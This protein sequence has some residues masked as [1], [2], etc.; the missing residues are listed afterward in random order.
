MHKCLCV[1]SAV[2]LTGF[3]CAKT[4]GQCTDLVSLVCRFSSNSFVMTR[5][6]ATQHCRNIIRLRYQNNRT[7]SSTNT[8]ESDDDLDPD[9]AVETID[10]FSEGYCGRGAAVGRKGVLQV[11]GPTPW[12]QSKNSVPETGWE[13]TPVKNLRRTIWKLHRSST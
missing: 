9:D 7:E 5:P 4:Y 11:K 1:S 10:D 6:Q 13:E 8:S 2:I 3:S 12:R